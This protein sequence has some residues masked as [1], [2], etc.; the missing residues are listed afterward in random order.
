MPFAIFI[1][2]LVFE[3][4]RRAKEYMRWLFDQL[5]GPVYVEGPS[6]EPSPAL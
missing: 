3:C 4:L 6:S 1:L 5:S 2:S